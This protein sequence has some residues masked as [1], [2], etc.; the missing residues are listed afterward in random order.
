[1]TTTR[2]AF[3]SV[4]ICTIWLSLFFMDCEFIM[5]IE[6]F[7]SS[8]IIVVHVL[9]TGYI[10]FAISIN[11]E[12]NICCLLCWLCFSLDPLAILL[13]SLRFLI[14]LHV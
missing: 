10:R 11:L 4:K 9:E 12:F 7:L 8:F 3:L 5:L 1:M 13:F 14:Y 6:T 2:L